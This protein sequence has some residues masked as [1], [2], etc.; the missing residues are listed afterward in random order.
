[1]QYA[2]LGYDPADVLGFH[3]KP[4]VCMPRFGALIQI[5]RLDTNAVLFT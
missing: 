1:M 2:R 4:L 5:W 3:H